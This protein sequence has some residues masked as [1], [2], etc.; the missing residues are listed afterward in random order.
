MWN[1]DVLAQSNDQQVLQRAEALQREY[2]DDLSPAFPPMQMVCFRASMQAEIAMLHS[3]TDLANMLIVEM[4]SVSSGFADIV[5]AMLLVLTLPV[6]V[7]TAERSFSKL[8]II[9]NYLRNTMG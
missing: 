6:T 4:A 1:P 3:A 5:T 2:E 8:K 9:K 7:A